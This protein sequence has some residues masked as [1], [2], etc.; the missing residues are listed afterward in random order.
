MDEAYG[1]LKHA[2]FKAR[3]QFLKTFQEPFI[4]LTEEELGCVN[5][6]ISKRKIADLKAS[7]EAL[8]KAITRAP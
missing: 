8:D 4:K 7:I 3:E 6:R 2:L 5:Y 1:A